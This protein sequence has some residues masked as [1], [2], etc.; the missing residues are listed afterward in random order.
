MAMN[1]VELNS[2]YLKK[3]YSISELAEILQRE[4]ETGKKIVLCHGVFDLLH[5]GHILHFKAAK[6]L[7]DILVVTVTPDRF[8]NKGPGR[9]YFNQR[10]RIESLS[11]LQSVDYVALNE[12]PTAVE[13]IRRLKPDVYAKGSDYADPSQDL[14]GKIAFEIAAVKEVGGQIVFTSEETFS[15]TNLLNQFFTTYPPE[16]EVFLQKFRKEHSA[17]EI[18]NCLRSLSDLKVVVVGESILDQY[19]Y[20]NPLGMSPKE[21]IIT[22]RFMSEENFAGGTLAIANHV[23]GFCNDV[24]L[25]TCLGQDQGTRDF[26]TSKLL[27]N[28]KLEA[29]ITEN[30]P[31]IIKRRFLE[32]TF[33]KKMF[34][35]QWLDE[36]LLPD[37]IERKVMKNIAE[38]I[39]GADVVII[40]DYGHGLFTENLRSLL[41]DSD[42]FLAVNVQSNSANFGFNLISKYSRADYVCI[43]ELELKLASQ[44]LHS[45]FQTVARQV[46]KKLKAQR[47]IV[48]RGYK[49]A[50]LMNQKNEPVEVPVASTKVLDR[51]GA[52]DAFFAITAPCAFKNYD[53]SVLGFI[54]NCVGAL[55]VNIV[56]N[57]EPVNPVLL[58]KFINSLLK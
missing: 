53:D 54:G 37:L 48:T 30:R 27:P 15:S 13:T 39:P 1:A 33:L 58:Y 29:V 4:K 55:A 34:E 57:K 17:D 43:D 32:P 28:V 35:I 42:K 45:H 12:W 19:C 20:C 49:G 31:T 41:C 2:N 8:V 10:L 24:T 6:R 3:N 36:S 52:G 14:T 25:V 40:A 44:S 7:G 56:C 51:V 26:I 46:L 23:A 38:A 16:T 18:I 47:I 50:L 21:G 9:P 11:A 5:P 22:T